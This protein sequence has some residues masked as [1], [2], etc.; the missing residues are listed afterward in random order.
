[1]H[2]CP[3][4]A[5]QTIYDLTCQD[6]FLGKSQVVYLKYCDATKMKRHCPEPMYR[7]VDRVLHNSGGTMYIM[8]IID[9]H[10]YY[11]NL[12]GGS[13]TVLCSNKITTLQQLSGRWR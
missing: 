3:H 6:N 10:I 11:D 1:M 9:L 8:D 12:S 7:C 4:K 5:I 2:T 13:N